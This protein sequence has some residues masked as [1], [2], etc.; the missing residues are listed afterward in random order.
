[1]VA[2]KIRSFSPSV[3]SFQPHLRSW[4]LDITVDQIFS[5][6]HWIIQQTNSCQSHYA[7]QTSLVNSNSRRITI[8]KDCPAKFLD[9][10][11]Y[12]YDLSHDYDHSNFKFGRN[13][14]TR[15]NKIKFNDLLTKH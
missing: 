15:R 12:R 6:L 2:E 13:G 3:T 8:Y 5:L 10:L 1:V 7:P 9:A 14:N 11:F 4:F